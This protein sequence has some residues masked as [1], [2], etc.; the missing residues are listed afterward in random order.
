VQ[1]PLGKTLLSIE[2]PLEEADKLAQMLKQNAGSDMRSHE[3]VFEVALR[4]D[5]PH[6][7]LRAAANAT[8]LDAGA[9]E[10]HCLRVRTLLWLQERLPQVQIAV[11][12]EGMEKDLEKLTGALPAQCP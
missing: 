3:A 12:R 5:K 4:L 11:A 8:E 7:A 9:A 2:K 10:A 1:D 6:H